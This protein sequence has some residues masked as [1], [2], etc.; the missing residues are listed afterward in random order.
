MLIDSH[1]HLDQLNLTKYNGQL[2]LAL[3][4]AHTVDVKY[5]LCPG[6]DL[7]HFPDIL[8]LAKSRSDVVIGLGK[9]PTETGRDPTLQELISLGQDPLVVGIGETG[10]DYAYAKTQAERNYQQELLRLHIQAALKLNKPL[11][12]HSRDSGADIIKILREEKA[13][14]VGGVFHCFTDTLSVAEE[15]LGLNFFI[16]FSGIITFKNAESLREV[17]KTIPLEKILLETDAPYLAPVPMRGKPNEPAYLRYVAEYLANLRGISLEQ[18][19]KQTSENFDKLFRL[20][21]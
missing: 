21:K 5:F 8:A 11:I 15:A 16:A 14:K 9:H 2:D 6:I 7:E 4:A 3:A 12:L 17:A 18:L 1:C 10:L 19:A 13:N 20:R